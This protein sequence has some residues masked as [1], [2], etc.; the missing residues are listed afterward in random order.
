MTP[1]SKPRRTGSSSCTTSPTARSNPSPGDPT[2]VICV[3]EFG[4]LNLQPHPGRH[5][6]AVGGTQKDPHRA[7]RR[8]RGRPTPARTGSAIC[9]PRYDC[10]PTGSTGTS[11]ITRAAPSSSRSAL[12]PFASPAARAHRHRDG[13]LLT[14]PVRPRTS[15][16]AGGPR[17]A[18]SL[19]RRCACR[20][21][22]A[23]YTV[24]CAHP[25]HV[26]HELAAGRRIVAKR[27]PAR[28]SSCSPAK[29]TSRSR[30]PPTSSTRWSTPSG[31]RSPAA[32]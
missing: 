18:T 22:P 21:A 25:T 24:N 1:T 11:R 20:V 30:R 17:P 14:A 7:P 3:D 29:P 15:A 5:W 23:Y 27:I 28:S 31:R 2:V 32:V 8:R 12:P 16:S 9:S 10:R 4:P 19:G 26:L 13:Q 6:A